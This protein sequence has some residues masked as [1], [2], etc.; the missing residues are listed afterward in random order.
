MIRKSKNVNKIEVSL[1]R[2]ADLKH[3][4]KFHYILHDDRYV[5]VGETFSPDQNL[6]GITK[7]TKDLGLV[8]IRYY[9]ATKKATFESNGQT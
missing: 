2:E 4:L 3:V 5:S 1:V 9:E 7:E 8:F 6:E